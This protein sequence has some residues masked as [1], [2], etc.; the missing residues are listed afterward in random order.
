MF[1]NNINNNNINI[2][3][4]NNIDNR[5]VNQECS[6]NVNELKQTKNVEPNINKVFVEIKRHNYTA[7]AKRENDKDLKRNDRNN[8][9]S[10]III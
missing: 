1:I 3:N 8:K 4:N 7:N 9:K 10:V 5:L 2:A 6:V